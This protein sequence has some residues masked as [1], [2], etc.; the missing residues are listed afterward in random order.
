M[1]SCVPVRLPCLDRN[2]HFRRAKRSI[3]AGGKTEARLEMP[4]HVALISEAS[5]V[6]GISERD[7]AGNLSLHPIEAPAD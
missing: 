3:A 6:S 1:P 4:G 7:A 2:G 5:G